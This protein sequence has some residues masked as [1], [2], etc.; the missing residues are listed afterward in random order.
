MKTSYTQVELNKILLNIKPRKGWDFSIMK[1]ERQTIPWNYDTT[2][3]KYLKKSDNVLD[4]GTGGGENFLK[5]SPLISSGTGIDID[6]DMIKMAKKNAEGTSNMD[7]LEMD[8]SLDELSGKFNIILSR[9]APYNLNAIKDHLV[10]N[11]YFITQQV[12]ENNMRNVKKVLG[13]EITTPVVTKSEFLRSGFECLVFEK[14]DV[15]YIVKD[16]ESL[17]FWLNALDLEHSDIHG[18]KALQNVET[19]N[20]ILANNVDERGFVTNEERFLV[21]AQK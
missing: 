4:I 7:F 20:K 19:L 14:Y 12:G 15:E 5:F 2:V 9:H 11:G 6:S 10:P 16:I 3:R 18:G 1:T 17:V 21:V 13:Q 8:D